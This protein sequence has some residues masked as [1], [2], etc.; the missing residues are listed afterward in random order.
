[1]LQRYRVGRTCRRRSGRLGLVHAPVRVTTRLWVVQ[2]GRPSTPTVTLRLRCSLVRASICCRYR[3]RLVR[4]LRPSTTTANLRRRCSVVRAAISGRHRRCS[5]VRAAISSSRRRGTMVR[6]VISAPHRRGGLVRATLDGS[7]RQ[8]AIV[9]ATSSCSRRRGAMERAAISAPRRR[10]EPRTIAVGGGGLGIC[11]RRGCHALTR[12]RPWFRVA[13]WRS[14]VP[15]RLRVGRPRRCPKGSLGLVH[16]FARAGTRLRVV[17]LLRPSTTRVM[18]RRLG[19]RAALWPPHP[20][21]APG[22]VVLRQAVGHQPLQQL[23]VLH[24]RVDVRQQVAQLL[25]PALALSVDHRLQLPAVSPER[26][27]PIPRAHQFGIHRRDQLTDLARGLPLRLL[28]QFPLDALAQR[29][30]RCTCYRS[31]SCFSWCSRFSCCSSLSCCRR[32]FRCSSFSR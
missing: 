30:A 27:Q 14:P 11:C 20:S 32:C 28:D 29:R 31:C 21:R 12:A 8:R 5:V 18:F 22:R 2:L 4:L 25:Q 23:P 9:P 24:R 6:A 15:R 10:R 17:R 7:R 19:C 16:A 1:M 3:R 13:L 26:P